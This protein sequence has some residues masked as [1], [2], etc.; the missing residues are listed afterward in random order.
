MN[1]K[2][3]FLCLMVS[4][5]YCKAQNIPLY[6]GTY[7]DGSSK[8]IYQA[9]FNSQTGELS[10]FQLAAETQ[11]P[12]YIAYSPNK[13]FIYAVGEGGT[14]TVSAFKVKENETLEFLNTV[15]SNGGAPCHISINPAG[16]K[17]VVS[18][19][20]GG[21]VSLY[22]I[23][24]DG[25]LK[26][27]FQVFEYNTKDKASHAHSAQFFNSSLFV[28]DLGMDAI[29]L[30]TLNNDNKTYDLVSSSSV[31]IQEKAGPRHFVITKDGQFIY[32]INEYASTVTASK[33]EIS[34]FFLID[35]YST[36]SKD[37]KKANSC[38]DIHL[39]KNENFLYGSNRG[40]NTIVVFKR[41]S[42][43]GTLTQIQNIDVEGEWPRNFTIDPTGKFLLVA[44][45]HSNNISI[46]KINPESGILSYLSSAKTPSPV[47]LLF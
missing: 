21:N 40:E 2:L 18:N 14:G 22:E 29:Y 19:Y 10:N 45:Q 42:V 46:F 23:K 7:T 32:N 44:N 4:L 33:K 15:P 8:G 37:Y 20:V 11:D 12:S 30:Y 35:N 47:C 43:D 6:I 3:F 25:T 38:A 1:F 16:D 13:K 26:P 27:A 17:A 39:S 5:F 34:G 9:K 36:L 31:S 28:S 24:A 41:N